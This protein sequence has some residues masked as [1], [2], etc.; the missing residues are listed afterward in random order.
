MEHVS[1]IMPAYNAE[2]F[3]GEAIESVIQQTYQSW[4]LIIVDDGSKDG[5][6]KIIESYVKKKPDKIT[7]IHKKQN[8]GTVSGLNTLLESANGEYICW[9]SA[10]DSYKEN[11]LEDSIRF[12]ESNKEYDLVFSDYEF[13]DENSKIIGIPS[14]KKYKEELKEKKTYQPYRAF[15]TEGCCAHFCTML[16]HS[17]CYEKV[18]NFNPKY[19]YAHDYDMWLRLVTEYKVGYIESVNLR[20]REYS[21]QISQQGNN[22]IDALNVL[23][24][25]IQNKEKLEKLYIKS[26]FSTENEALTALIKRQL[27]T[28]KHRDKEREH[29]IK[30]LF[31]KENKVLKRFWEKE[32]NSLLLKIVNK[33]KNQEWNEKESIFNDIGDKSYLNLLCKLNKTDGFILN[34][35]AI[36]F[37]QFKGNTIDHFNKGLMRSNDII[38][39]KV[40]K[41]KLLKFLSNC[42]GEYRYVIQSEEKK[43][44]TIGISYYMYKNM[45]I[46]NEL[47]MKEIVDTNT[48]IWWQLI[49]KLLSE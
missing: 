36:R 21:W 20:G 39:G 43:E 33:I 12:L 47:G 49:Q 45:N 11:I 19:K 5:T 37:D 40:S 23:F 42:K 17:Y 8:Q 35:K 38:K 9:L 1:V 13:M 44:L 48:D 34:K 6:K 31:D 3:I 2:R 18:G 7:L 24:Q 28:Y 16:C 4:K 41:E 15:L 32:E 27:V 14:F 30:L 10:D 29:L 25:F 26:G 46:T 22:E